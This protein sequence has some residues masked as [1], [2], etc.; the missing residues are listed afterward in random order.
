[1]MNTTSM[2][3]GRDHYIGKSLAWLV[4]VDQPKGRYLANLL[5]LACVLQTVNF[6]F[7]LALPALLGGHV[8]PKAAY[9]LPGSLV[10][11]S[12]VI[13]PVVENGALAFA[14]ELTPQDRSLRFKFFVSATAG[15]IAGLLH[16]AVP[17]RI[18]FAI[19]GFAVMSFVYLTWRPHSWW[20]AY[21]AG[22]AFH[23]ANNGSAIVVR[24]VTAFVLRSI[25]PILF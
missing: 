21:T 4:R 13:A 2:Q 17:V 24:K 1:M 22:V 3:G 16:A 9:P 6:V 14:L 5:A 12:V 8:T 25:Q 11:L 20:F 18:P 23:A 7:L 10:L 15:L 19:I